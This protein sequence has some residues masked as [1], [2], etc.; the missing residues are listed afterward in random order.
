MSGSQ[1]GR[2]VRITRPGVTCTNTSVPV[3]R[4]SSRCSSHTIP[5]IPAGVQGA[6]AEY[7][8]GNVYLC[9]GWNEH[10]GGAASGTKERYFQHSP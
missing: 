5:D 1:G 2:R 6:N 10:E 8:G 4:T 3:L 7:M 9:G